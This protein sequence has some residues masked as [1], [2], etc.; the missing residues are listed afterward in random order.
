M[1]VS[2]AV[3]S[4]ASET[5]AIVD[6]SEFVLKMNETFSQYFDSVHIILDLQIYF[7][8]PDTAKPEHTIHRTL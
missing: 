8:V 7:D 2:L 1:V 3:N 6:S 4:F 5:L